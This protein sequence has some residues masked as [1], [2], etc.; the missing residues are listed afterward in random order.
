MTAFDTGGSSPENWIAFAV[1]N[2]QRLRKSTKMSIVNKAIWIIEC[3]LDRPNR[4]EAIAEACQVTP[5]H[6]SHRF[7][8]CLG[9]SLTG[10]V[11]LRRLSRGPAQ[12]AGGA[13]DILQ[14]V[15]EAGYG[16]HEALARAF[17]KE[18][19]RSPASLRK[20][21]ALEGLAI[22]GPA[23]MIDDL[24]PGISV[25]GRRHRPSTR[26]LGLCARV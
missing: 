6:L 8:A 2:L 5:A 20:Q 22:T 10:Y 1:R 17:M 16:S 4:L 15:L 14:V 18:F 7:S 11:R 24:K 21:K 3:H 26:Y 25:L 9:N 23:N 19:G 12:L 13:S